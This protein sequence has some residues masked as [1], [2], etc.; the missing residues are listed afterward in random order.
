MYTQTNSKA[1]VPDI[2]DENLNLRVMNFG[3]DDPRRS[4]RYSRYTSV[5]PENR[6]DNS[7][8]STPYFL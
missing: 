1:I 8:F 5:N 7:D 4:F 3:K 2:G 6:G